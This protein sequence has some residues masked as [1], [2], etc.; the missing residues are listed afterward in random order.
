MLN[1]R[2]PNWA[3]SSRRCDAQLVLSLRA[4][5]HALAERLAGI[6]AS[7]PGLCT[8]LYYAARNVR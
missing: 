3:K 7:R 8:V 1:A 6:F 5:V 4:A 2:E